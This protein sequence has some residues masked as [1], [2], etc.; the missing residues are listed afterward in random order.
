MSPEEL[1]GAL[2]EIGAERYH[3]RHPFHQRMRDGKLTRGQ[4]QVWALNRY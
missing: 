1:H 2:Q 3:S 4:I